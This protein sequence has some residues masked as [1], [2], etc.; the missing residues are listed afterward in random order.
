MQP[1]LAAV[2]TDARSLLPARGRKRATRDVAHTAQSDTGAST[3]R[4]RLLIVDDDWLIS[5]HLEQV[6]TTAGFEIV[7]TASDAAS[8]V[9]LAER[10]RPD[11]V[12][13]DIR[14]HGPVDGVEAAR[15]IVDR[16][17]IQSLFVSAHTDQGTIT[18]TLAARPRGWLPKPFTEAE[19]LQAV[20][21]ALSVSGQ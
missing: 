8:A 18:R 16:L 19:V 9:A 21:A 6:L 10:E 3:R 12:L 15:E 1:L 5:M 14:L 20:R 17:G 7:G 4:H 2:T 11:L 13:M